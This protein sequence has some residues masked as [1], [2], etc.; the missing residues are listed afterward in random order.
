[1]SD[2]AA[3]TR[4]GAKEQT[5]R[6]C[7]YC[8]SLLGAAA[9]VEEQR[10]ALDE[11]QRLLAAT[12]SV[13]ARRKLLQ[14]GYL[15]DDEGLLVQ[16]GV[17]VV[18]L[19]EFANAGDAAAA[20]LSAIALKLKLLSAP[21]PATQKAIGEFEARCREHEHGNARFFYGCIGV[22]LALVAFAVWLAFLR[23]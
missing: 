14:T 4:C 9:S 16:A 12:T 1:M 23:R 8:G 18:P 2:V 22:V 7:A 5:G 21:A 19:V 11:L 6:L 17:S 13:D 20:R 10:A 15:P 3:C